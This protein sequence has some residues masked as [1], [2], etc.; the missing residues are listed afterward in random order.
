[1]SCATEQPC[2]GLAIAM[3]DG[4]IK[5]AEDAKVPG[6]PEEVNVMFILGEPIFDDDG[7]KKIRSHILNRCPF[8]GRP[9]HQFIDNY[10]PPMSDGSSKP[11]SNL[12]LI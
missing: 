2:V 11:K 7:S 8:C 4:A 9:F 12:I 1:M 6:L 10:A 3:Q 5:F